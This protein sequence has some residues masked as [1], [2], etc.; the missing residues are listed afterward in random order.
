MQS[1]LSWILGKV[2]STSV[3]TPVMSKPLTSGWGVSM[4]VQRIMK[5]DGSAYNECSPYRR[6]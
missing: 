4:E 5:R 6:L 2:R 3:T 1:H